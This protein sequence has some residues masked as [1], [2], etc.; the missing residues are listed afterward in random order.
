MGSAVVPDQTNLPFL[1]DHL[2][3]QLL[4]PG[5]EDGTIYSGLVLVGVLCGKSVSVHILKASWPLVLPYG[6]VWKLLTTSHVGTRQHCDILFRRLA[7]SACLPLKHVELG[8]LHLVEKA[9]L[10]TVENI[11]CRVL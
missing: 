5:G 7:T 4:H 10:I 1:H 8:W 6:Q 2:V 3:A 11:F 9:C